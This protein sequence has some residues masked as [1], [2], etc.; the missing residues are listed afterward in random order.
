MT[1]FRIDWVL[2]SILPPND[3]GW[4]S[5]GLCRTELYAYYSSRLL[6]AGTR[7]KYR[8]GSQTAFL[9]IILH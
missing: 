9:F 3:S 2:T 5:P 1:W 8:L 7:Y 4:V 6:V